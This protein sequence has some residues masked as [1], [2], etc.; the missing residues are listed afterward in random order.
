MLLT[1]VVVRG[2]R[3][4]TVAHS[5][6]WMVGA[7]A[8][9]V[10]GMIQFDDGAFCSQSSKAVCRDRVDS[11]YGSRRAG[12]CHVATWERWRKLREGTAS[13]RADAFRAFDRRHSPWSRGAFAAPASHHRLGTPLVVTA[14]RGS[15]RW[16]GDGV[17]CCHRRATPERGCSNTA[18]KRPYSA[19]RSVPACN[20]AGLTRLR[21]STA[22]ARLR[23]LQKSTPNVSLR[24]SIADFTSTSSPSSSRR[25]FAHPRRRLRSRR[26]VRC[27]SAP[28]LRLEERRGD[29]HR[30]SRHG[31]RE[32]RTKSLIQFRRRIGQIC[33]N[34]KRRP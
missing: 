19:E 28:I 31:P 15:L 26:Y 3:L 14:L 13:D 11:A 20:R 2:H 9:F 16:S 21:W 34:S 4:A 12:T 1:F 17:G 30:A 25:R 6:T 22:A 27:S 23:R 10:V 24:R 8:T 18:T 32:T 33:A 7:F 5:L 29:F